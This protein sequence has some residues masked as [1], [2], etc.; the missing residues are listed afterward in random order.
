MFSKGGRYS[1]EDRRIKQGAEKLELVSTLP[2]LRVYLTPQLSFIQH[3]E[4]KAAH[5]NTAIIRLGR[6]QDVDVK[7]V[8]N[9]FQVMVYSLLTHCLKDIAPFLN[10]NHLKRLNGIQSSYLKRVL[11]LAKRSS[12]TAAHEWLASV[13]S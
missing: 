3:K 5:A 9:L 12:A 7:T 2:Y 13:P 8:V 4:M 1:V 10:V 6:L 11:G